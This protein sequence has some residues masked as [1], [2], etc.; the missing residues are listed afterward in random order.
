M[1]LMA[2]HFSIRKKK[3]TTSANHTAKPSSTDQH[4]PSSIFNY[5]LQGNKPKMQIRRVIIFI[6][7]CCGDASCV[8]RWANW[9][10]KTMFVPN[11]QHTHLHKWIKTNTFEL[12][13]FVYRVKYWAKVALFAHTAYASWVK[14]LRWFETDSRRCWLQTCLSHVFLCRVTRKR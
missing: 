6:L 7:P 1:R 9:A 13:T 10:T 2:T 5:V 12:F 14:I 3:G 4:M 8:T 11:A